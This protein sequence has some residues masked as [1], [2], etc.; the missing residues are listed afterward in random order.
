[1]GTSNGRCRGRSSEDDAELQGGALYDALAPAYRDLSQR[2]RPYLD[3]IDRLITSRTR[4]GAMSMLDV[5][6]GD[7]IR[8]ARLASALDIRRLV[9][10]EPSAKM[11]SLC[12]AHAATAS[13]VWCAPVEELAPT[14]VRFDVITCLWNVLGHVSN[15]ARR[16]SALSRMRALLAKDGQIFIDTTHRYNA[17]AYGSLRTIARLVVDAVRPSERNGDIQLKW[18]VEGRAVRGR[19]HAFTQAE[20]SRLFAMAGMSV[21]DAR[22]IDYR[23]GEARR[24][25]WMGQLY[26]ELNHESR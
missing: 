15:H 21:L 16:A 7:G 11:A 18:I 22:F 6:A 24:H 3:A 1:M 2:R 23:T 9:L 5:G 10:L 20:M 19:G 8:A 25:W 14:N 26:F 12:R 13:E 4:R 17:L